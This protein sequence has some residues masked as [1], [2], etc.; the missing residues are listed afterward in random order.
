MQVR[1]VE[2]RFG[3]VELYYEVIGGAEACGVEE[4]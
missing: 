3:G 2:K 4:S 1:I